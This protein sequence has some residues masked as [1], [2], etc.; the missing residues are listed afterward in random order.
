MPTGK[1]LK[2][3]EDLVATVR[4]FF[5][6]LKSIRPL[7]TVPVS[8]GWTKC[9]SSGE[10]NTAALSSPGAPFHENQ[11]LGH[12]PGKPIT[13]KG[14]RQWNFSGKDAGLSLKKGKT[15]LE[16]KLFPL[17]RYTTIELGV[18]KHSLPQCH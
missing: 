9:L 4:A 7:L 10:R 1:I 6:L 12:C 14:G 15:N 2:R 3:E 18:R 8:V 16:P 11:L 5:L 17:R 13:Q